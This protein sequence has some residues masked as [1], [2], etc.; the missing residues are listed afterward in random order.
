MQLNW[1]RIVNS[2][3]VFLSIIILFIYATHGGTIDRGYN[4]ENSISIA[5]QMRSSLCLSSY[6]G[7][8]SADEINAIVVDKFA[9]IFIA[10]ST[11]SKNFPIKNAFQNKKMGGI[12]DGFIAKLDSSGSLIF[13]TH[14]GGRGSDEIRA[15]VLDDRGDIYVAGFTESTDF[16]TTPGAYQS[17]RSGSFAK[18]FVAKLKADGSLVY[19]S[20]LGGRV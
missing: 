12:F 11:R 3:S 2:S 13:S 17:K 16:P 7:G 6:L 15:A 19:S 4:R 1:T 14:F 20:Y 8:G 5:S 10:G 9:N 18:A